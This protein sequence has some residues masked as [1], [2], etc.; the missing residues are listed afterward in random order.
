ME[1]DGEPILD[2]DGLKGLVRLLR[3]AQVLGLLHVVVYNAA[4]KLDCSS[5][6]EPAL[7]NSEDLP[8]NEVA[9]HPHEDSSKRLS[10][11]V[12]TLTGELLK[13]LASIAPS[14]RKFFFSKNTETLNSLTLVDGNKSKGV[15]SDGNQE[16]ITLW[17]E[18]SECIGVTESQLG[19]GSLSSVVNANVGDPSLPLGTQRLLPF[20]EAFLVLCDKLQE[21]CSLL[22]QD[23]ACAKESKIK[24][25]ISSSSQ[26]QTTKG[27][28]TFTRFDEKH[29]RLLNAF[30]RQ[31]PGLLEKALSMLLK[32]P[33]ETSFLKK[34]KAKV[35]W[36]IV[37]LPKQEGGL[38]VHRRLSISKEALGAFGKSQTYRYRGRWYDRG[39]EAEHK[40]VEIMEDRRYKN[41]VEDH[42]M[43]SGASF[44]ATYCKEELERFKLRSGKVHLA[45]DKTL[46][47]AAVGDLDEEGYHIG[48]GDQQ[49]KVTKDSLVVAHGNKRGSQY[50]VEV[51]PEGIGAIINGSGSAAVWFGE[52]EESFLYNVSKDKETA[53]VGA[54]G[55]AKH[56]Y[57]LVLLKDKP[58]IQSREHGDS[59]RGSEDVIGLRIP[60]EEWRGK[61]TSRTLEVAQM[62]C[63]TAF[64]YEESPDSS[65]LTKPIQKSQVLLVDIPKNLIENDSIVAE[66]GLKNG[67]P[68]SYSEA[69]S[70]K[71][72][73]QWKKAINEEMVSLEKNQTWSL[74]RLPVG[75]KALQSK[76]V[77]R[78][79]E[80]VLIYVEDSWNEELCSDVHQVSDEREVE[81]LHSFNWPPSELITDDGVLLERDYSQFND[82]RKVRAVALL[83]GRWFEVY[84]DYLRRRAVKLARGVQFGMDRAVW[85]EPEQFSSELNNISLELYTIQRSVQSFDISNAVSDVVMDEM[86]ADMDGIGPLWDDIADLIKSLSSKGSVVSIACSFML[87]DLDFEPLSLSLSSLPSCDLII[88]LSRWIKCTLTRIAKL[89][90]FDVTACA[91]CVR[92]FSA[93]PTSL[94]AFSIATS[95]LL[96]SEL[97]RSLN[98]LIS[99]CHLVYELMN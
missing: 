82:Y 16:H 61:D 64:G 63:D 88:S 87:C 26:S 65:S 4:S 70:S 36:N 73:V 35:A 99:P 54:I 45:D 21:K 8:N 12:Y 7:T 75:K 57:S 69:L 76:W 60:E 62:K 51:H 66:H 91:S 34:G 28:V 58:N 89:S 43:D 9:G 94:C 78:V 30:V 93:K 49:W 18:L 22:Q 83:K 39:Q 15:E 85:H 24:Q 98:R 86:W 6:T 19:Q 44:H 13:K 25:S 41:T 96:L 84:K 2:A 32:A 50:M 72:F 20:I 56:L 37:C 42:N 10:D 95:F 33:T 40:Q 90:F 77:F 80:E 38:D 14:H 31:D 27:T 55:V 74:V 79:K 48:F 52:A 97:K 46:D 81:V 53:E 92:A 67:E 1:V 23:N 59:C 11:T 3:L 17:Q 47:I 68:E 5:P 29:R 71:E